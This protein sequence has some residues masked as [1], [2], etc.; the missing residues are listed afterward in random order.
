MAQ[1]FRQDGITIIELDEAYN[2]LD[3]EPIEAL[4]RLLLSEAEKAP[5]PPLLLLD[6]SKTHY[7]G[8]R[9]LEVL[10]RTWKRLKDRK[11]RMVLCGVQPFC[12]EVL[13]ITHLDRI[14]ET[15]P[16]RQAGFDALHAKAAG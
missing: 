3:E 10:F 16:D 9:V 7:I 11:G 13:Q 1:A 5:N 4:A 15:V 6:F 2:A 12:G 14:W 8:S